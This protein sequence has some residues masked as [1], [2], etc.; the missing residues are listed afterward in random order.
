MVISPRRWC[1]RAWVVP[2]A[3]LATRDCACRRRLRAAGGFL[4][5]VVRSAFE[6]L[7]G[8]VC[9][10]ASGMSR[11]IPQAVFQGFEM[12]S[13]G[14]QRSWGCRGKFGHP[15]CMRLVGREAVDRTA[16]FVCRPKDAAYHTWGHRA[17][18][19]KACCVAACCV[20]GR[21]RG[22]ARGLVWF[23]GPGVLRVVGWWCGSGREPCV[24][25]RPGLLSGKSAVGRDISTD[26]IQQGKDSIQRAEKRPETI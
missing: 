26:S 11:A 1:L 22:G 16:V 2:W 7:C 10:G 13:L 6:A 17:C 3:S 9:C 5:R 15:N 18:A 8:A 20:A 19:R 21:G 14:L 24:G 4:L 12:R 25:S 23:C